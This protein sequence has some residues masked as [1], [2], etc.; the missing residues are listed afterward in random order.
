MPPSIRVGRGTYYPEEIVATTALTTPYVLSDAGALE[1][2]ELCAAGS[3]PVS[4]PDFTTQLLEGTAASER[5]AEI[6]RRLV[7]RTT[8]K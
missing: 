4:N 8:A 3:A 2:A 1:L 6:Q 7:D 5:L